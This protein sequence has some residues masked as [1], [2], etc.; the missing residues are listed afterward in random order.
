MRRSL[1]T[2]AVALT[3]AA[4]LA[5]IT[6]HAALAND[7]GSSSTSGY[8]TSGYGTSGFGSSTTNGYQPSAAPATSVKHVTVNK[9]TNVTQNNGVLNGNTISLGLD[10]AGNLILVP[11]SALNNSSV[12]SHIGALNHSLNGTAGEG[13]IANH[14]LN[15][16]GLAAHVLQNH[17]L[18]A[19]TL[20]SQ[21]DNN[22]AAPGTQVNS[23]PVDGLVGGLV[24]GITDGGVVG[25]LTGN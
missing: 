25:G 18:S 19:K 12:L 6:S 4:G 22:Q 2:L 17:G 15:G 21:V 8:G 5:A 13:G 23:G 3:A 1:R 20:S 7:H 16:S 14:D 10:P 11:I 9:H 24:G